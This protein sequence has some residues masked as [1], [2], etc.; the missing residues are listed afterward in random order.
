MILAIVIAAIPHCG[1]PQSASPAA[2]EQ[3][4]VYVD[5]TTL[6]S[7]HGLERRY[8]IPAD[9]WIFKIDGQDI[10]LSRGDAGGDIG[11]CDDDR[12]LCLNT[13]ALPFAVPKGQLPSTWEFR[14]RVY[15]LLDLDREV[16]VLGATYEVAVFTVD[17]PDEDPARVESPWALRVLLLTRAWFVGIHAGSRRLRRGPAGMHR[18]VLG[19]RSRRCLLAGRGPTAFRRWR[20]VNMTGF[21]TPSI[22]R[23]PTTVFGAPLVTP[24]S[25]PR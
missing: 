20:D 4:T 3:E 21:V 17:V 16:Q 5:V 22:V 11:S 12:F 13:P 8:S 24:A 9:P 1:Y 15:R 25:L 7:V 19:V 23:L 14:S 6:L 10:G 18:W 2:A